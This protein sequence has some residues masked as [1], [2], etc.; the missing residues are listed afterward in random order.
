[1]IPK[2]TYLTASLA[3]VCMAFIASGCADDGVAMEGGGVET[4]ANVRL[5]VP[6]DSED[7]PDRLDYE[8]VCNREGLS[9]S[10]VKGSLEPPNVN[11]GSDEI[12][13]STW[14]ASVE[15]PPGECL[16]RVTTPIPL[17]CSSCRVSEWVTIDPGTVSDVSLVL[18]CTLS[19]CVPSGDAEIRISVPD[20]PG[21]PELSDQ[22]AY[23]VTC[24]GAETDFPASATLSGKL[25]VT[26]SSGPPRWQTIFTDLP[27]GR[28]NLH[29]VASDTSGEARCQATR[30]FYIRVDVPM[31]LS[32][33]LQCGT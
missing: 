23:T 14:T 20:D 19:F 27:A 7:L 22:L 6:G 8:F 26:E 29:A 11:P 5:I 18:L 21:V 2:T 31:T 9:E 15:L 33:D 24:E 12:D 3:A 4:G 17:D 30:D 32:V 16:F 25:D 10:Q 28:C 1:V 13:Q